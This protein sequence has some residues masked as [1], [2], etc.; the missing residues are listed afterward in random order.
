MPI[1]SKTHHIQ[2]ATSIFSYEES[3]MQPPPFPR[4]TLLKYPSYQWNG[5]NELATKL[6]YH[7]MSKASIG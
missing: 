5:K 1:S 6:R 2:F 7:K 4:E 3:H